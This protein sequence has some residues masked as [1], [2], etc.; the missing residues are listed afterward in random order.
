M[1]R[2]GKARILTEDEWDLVFETIKHNRHPERNAAVMRLSKELGLKPSELAFLKIKHVATFTGSS[3]NSERSIQL[4]QKIAIVIDRRA[5][6]A[7]IKKRS[8][9][10]TDH[11]RNVT[12]TIAEFADVLS[13]VI[14]LTKTGKEVNPKD[15][16]PRRRD[17]QL[18]DRELPLVNVALKS[19]LLDYIN[20]RISEGNTISTNDF[21]FI[22]AKAVQFTPNTMQKMMAKILTKWAGL[23]GASG[24]SGRVG[25][26][27]DLVNVKKTPI[28]VAQRI[29][30]HK[31][32]GTTAI[33]FE[34]DD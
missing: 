22:S 17:N 32:R 20:L 28:S 12:F 23:D 6:Q 26:G 13:T 5:R 19:S 15:Y 33:V 14:S 9:Y 18:I 25:L 16:Y 11:R 8:E 30:G 4:N 27:N 1:G 21:L 10:Y 29:L 3:N 7:A 2:T 34:K 31:S 24:T